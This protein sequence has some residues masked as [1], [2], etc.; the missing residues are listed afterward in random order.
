[1]GTRPENIEEARTGMLSFFGAGELQAT[2]EEIETA[3][4]KYISRM[5]MR[6]VTSMG[7]AFTLSQD[8]FLYGDVDYAATEARGLET[9]TP[10]AVNR[11]VGRYLAGDPV[12]TVI[13]R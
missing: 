10:E 2:P 13:A 7:Q 8:Y 1:M 3:S 4:N 6:R 12:V 5:R 11:V 9:V